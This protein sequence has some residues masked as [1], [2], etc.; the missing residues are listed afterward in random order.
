MSVR[1]LLAAVA[2]VCGFV[3]TCSAQ[4]PGGGR[5]GPG[6][7]GGR[8]PMQSQQMSGGGGQ[9]MMSRGGYGMGQMQMLQQQQQYAALLGQYQAQ[10]TAMQLLTENELGRQNFARMQAARQAQLKAGK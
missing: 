4:G 2:V 3:G 9:G 5:C 10:L 6:G 1:V 7:G 8:G